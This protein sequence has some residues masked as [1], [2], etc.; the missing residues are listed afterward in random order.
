MS[1]L[2][3]Y[4][5][6]V[7]AHELSQAAL[8]A[9]HETEASASKLRDVSWRAAVLSV[10]CPEPGCQVPEFTACIY[11]GEPPQWLHTQRSD[12]S[13]VNG[14]LRQQEAADRAAAG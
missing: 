6:A 12:L 8:S 2:E 9:A 1:P 11:P 5:L 7:T 10:A 13:G 4:Q 14:A 3:T